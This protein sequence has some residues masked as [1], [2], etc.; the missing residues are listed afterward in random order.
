MPEEFSPRHL[1]V[2]VAEVAAVVVAAVVAISA[3][4]GLD[5]VRVRLTDADPVG[6]GGVVVAE[7]GVVR[8]RTARAARRSCSQMSWRLSYDIAM[9]ELAANSLLPT[10]GAGAALG[11]WALR[12][13]GNADRGYRAALGGVL[14]RDERRELRRARTRRPR[15]V[16][17][18][19]AGAGFGAARP[20]AGAHRRGGVRSRCAVA[21]P[22]ARARVR[23]R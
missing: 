1:A 5:E 16:R 21:K 2:R 8:R 6:V 23:T 3:L 13:G 17:R 12:E 18:G 20:R 14:C 15:R 10:G 22:A 7:L 9:A 11:V 4:P 19:R